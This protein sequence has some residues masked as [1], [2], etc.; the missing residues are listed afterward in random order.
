MP[1]IATHLRPGSAVGGDTGGQHETRRVGTTVLQ[2]VAVLIVVQLAFFALL[3]VA[4]A[5]PDG[6][7]VTH[8]QE[9][10]DEGIYGPT[11]R[12]DNMGSESTS[13][14]ECVLVGVGLGRPDWNPFE[15]AARMPRI[16]SC[17]DG[18]ADIAA[19]ARGDTPDGVTEYFRYWAGWTVLSRPVLALW[20]L[21]ALRRI[22]GA[23]L[24]LAAGTFLALLAKRTKPAYALALALPVLLGSNILAVP[25]TSLNQTISLSAAFLSPVLVMVAVP[26]GWRATLIATALGAAIYNYV[27]LMLTPA[28]PWMLSTT[29]TAAMLLLRT[30][31]W[32]PAIQRALAV[33][34]VWPCA[35][36]FTWASRWVIAVVLVGWDEAVTNIRDKVEFRLGGSSASVRDEVGASTRVSVDYWLSEISTAAT[37][38]VAA[39]VVIV[40]ALVVA[41]R[42]HGASGLAVFALLAAPASFALVWYELV[43]NHSQIH[44]GKAHMS[45]PVALG[46]VVGAAVFTAGRRHGRPGAVSDEGAESP[47]VSPH[48]RELDRELLVE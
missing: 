37:V 36:A 46:V 27:D 20:G 12:P 8:L 40:V 10:V 41:V 2:V 30:G 45:L 48:E 29:T 26:R 33:A 1:P 43:R 47:H 4:Q 18:P 3:V 44:P 28:I 21:D 25:S 13:F 7:I 42:R 35:F 5:V 15:R 6:S 17:A 32:K 24:V 34:I 19:L 14:D 23:L 39:G 16:G 9:A 38:L 22:A 31:R 11:G